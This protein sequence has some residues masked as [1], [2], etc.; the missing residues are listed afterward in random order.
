MKIKKNFVKR[1]VGDKYLVVNTKKG[2]GA[3][4]MFI[5]MNETSSFIWDQFEKGYDIDK[6]AMQL[7]K[8][9]SIPKEKA[10]KDINKLVEAMK[11][12]GIIED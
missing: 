8:R 5:E 12:A 9:Y 11:N 3:Q 7:C 1:K 6:T 4:S 10:L 2:D